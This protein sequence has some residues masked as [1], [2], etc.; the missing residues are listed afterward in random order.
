MADEQAELFGTD[1]ALRGA[2]AGDL[3]VGR[4]G[5]LT[6][7]AGEDNI[8]QALSLRLSVR[9][10]ELA[11]LGLPDFGSRLHELVGEPNNQR[12]RVIATGHA[13]T[14]VEQDP[15][16]ARVVRVEARSGAERDT[17]R[18]DMDILLITGPNPLNLVLEL[19][20]SPR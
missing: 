13:R 12:T 4:R 18:V 7:A 16:V 20:L 11:R 15:R 6:L 17:V 10:G 9:R 14:A 19:P 1:L 8:V 3:V 2:G 5:D